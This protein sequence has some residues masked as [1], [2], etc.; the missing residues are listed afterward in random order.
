MEQIMMWMLLQCTE[1]R[2]E[3]I[4]IWVFKLTLDRTTSKVMF[5]GG[6]LGTAETN[7]KE[8]KM[9]EKQTMQHISQY[10]NTT[11]ALIILFLNKKGRSYGEKVSFWFYI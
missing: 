10:E 2:E 1:Q 4:K 6:A 7:I 3:R 11:I 8:R 5:C 9:S